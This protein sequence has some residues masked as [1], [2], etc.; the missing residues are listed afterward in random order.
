MH[1]LID[2][3][4]ESAHEHMHSHACQHMHVNI[5]MQ[6]VAMSMSAILMPHQSV[7]LPIP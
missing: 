6:S 1:V 7:Q 3:H 5:I 2:W 4:A